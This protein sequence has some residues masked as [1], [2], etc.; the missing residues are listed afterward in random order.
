MAR[1]RSF[2]GRPTQAARR[3]TVWARSDI[4]T[5]AVLTA[6]GVRILDL[7]AEVEA[8]IGV[9]WIPGITIGPIF[10]TIQIWMGAEVTPVPGATHKVGLG[11]MFTDDDATNVPDPETDSSDWMFRR[12]QHVHV[13]ADQAASRSYP[14]LPDGL[15]AFELAV[16][17][18]RKQINNH[19][20]LN[21]I[22]QSSTVPGS[23]HEPQIVA[24]FNTLVT[25]P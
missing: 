6:T 23:G 7:L 21:L 5:P 24:A 25:L 12:V 8:D 17:S 2:R 9:N 11:I 10:G 18:K 15:S 22:G 13:S 16:R 4:S 20:S 19:V 1:T 3:R 14:A